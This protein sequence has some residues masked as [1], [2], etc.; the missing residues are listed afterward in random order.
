MSSSVVTSTPLVEN[1]AR[2]IG[3]DIAR[4][5]A[6][7][8][9]MAAHLVTTTQQ[10]PVTGEFLV[11]GTPSSTFALLGGIGAVLSTERYRRVAEP[12]AARRALVGRGLVLIV[13]GLILASF[14]TLIA[15]VLPAYGLSLI[16]L[17]CIIHL[18]THWLLG[19]TV[20]LTL[21]GAPFNSW[22]TELAASTPALS[23]PDGLGEYVSS[24]FIPGVYPT[25]TWLTYMLLGVLIARM[26]L[27]ARRSGALRRRALQMALIGGLISAA[28][29][30]L[31]LFAYSTI[32]VPVFERY[33]LASNAFM[34]GFGTP[35]LPGIDG[36]LLGGPHSGTVLDIA[37]TA[38]FAV[39]MLG[40]LIAATAALVR[41]PRPLRIL[42][43]AG[44][45]SLTIYSLHVIV[46]S[47]TTANLTD[48]NSIAIGYPG[49][50]LHVTGA[51]VLGLVLAVLHRRGPLEAFSS[52]VAKALAGVLVQEKIEALAAGPRSS[53]ATQPA[54][55]A[56]SD[57]D[58]QRSSE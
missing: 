34:S 20:V 35:M 55:G 28:A 57:V 37:R 3:I 5:L 22:L 40:L 17:A 11:S 24:F 45:A 25:M 42:Q 1:R 10:L 53:V 58:D 36:L 38:G 33:G 12:A 43:S 48:L 23:E 18:R 6:I 49:F 21:L 27:H 47:I 32:A 54:T 8:G 4:L 46:T 19:L 56:R 50:A 26:L 2:I 44:A 29:T 52:G 9:M 51:L 15:V 14:S 16:L 39:L 41:V 31:H 13:I 30:A 7:F